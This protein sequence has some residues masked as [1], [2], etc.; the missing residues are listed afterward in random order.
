MTRRRFLLLAL[1]CLLLA[2]SYAALWFAFA[3]P[4]S[5]INRANA[6]KIKLGM[7]RAEVEAILGGP[8]RDE[9]GVSKPAWAHGRSYECS[10]NDSGGRAYIA[11]ERDPDTIAV[12][13][14]AP[15]ISG[16]SVWR[17]RNAEISI[18]F[19]GDEFVG[20]RFCRIRRDWSR[21][22]WRGVVMQKLEAW[23]GGDR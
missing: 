15:G 4:A 16:W 1:L 14:H 23:F 8:V 19:S 17:S 9:S 2:G 20:F 5:A 12:N 10:F 18:R 22:G 11:A 6:L 13:A 7:T 3:P 21:E